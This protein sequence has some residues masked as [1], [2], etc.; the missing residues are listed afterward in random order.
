MT[1]YPPFSNDYEREE[2]FALGVINAKSS[3]FPDTLRQFRVPSTAP[4]AGRLRPVRFR[5]Q[6]LAASL[7]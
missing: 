6:S 2:A 1:R 3:G 7:R 5:R 4:R